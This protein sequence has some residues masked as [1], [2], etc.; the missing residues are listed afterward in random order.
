MNQSEESDL[1]HYLHVCAGVSLNIHS[2]I[3]TFSNL[4][5]TVSRFER[6]VEGEIGKRD[7]NI[8]PS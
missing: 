1:V 2:F 5:A 6:D 7:K 4:F 3:G 8:G